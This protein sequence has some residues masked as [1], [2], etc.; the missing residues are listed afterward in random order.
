MA[1]DIALLKA[2]D[3]YLSQ[4]W[5]VQVGEELIKIR[6]IH[7]IQVE[8]LQNAPAETSVG[9]EPFTIN[10]VVGTFC[11]RL[12]DEPFKGIYRI[13]TW[14]AAVEVVLTIKTVYLKEQL[15]NLP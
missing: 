11:A 9:K 1:F 2:V 15:K 3:N 14:R 4:V 8:E 10:S 5:E 13:L 12:S 7:N 6:A